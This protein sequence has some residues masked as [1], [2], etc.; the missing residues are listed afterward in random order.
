MRGKTE[1]FKIIT[2]AFV[3]SLCCQGNAFADQYWCN[4]CKRNVSQCW[5]NLAG[6]HSA[7]NSAFMEQTCRRSEESCQDICAKAARSEQQPS[8][9]GY[10]R[11]APADGGYYSPAP[12]APQR[13][14]QYCCENGGNPR[15]YA[16]PSPLGSACFCAGQ[17]YVI[18]CH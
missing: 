16:N 17:G 4:S 5:S 14:G 10:Y 11:P 8:G 6:M 18:I 7:V 2:T 1:I 15:C 3:L 12:A 9:G 13:Y